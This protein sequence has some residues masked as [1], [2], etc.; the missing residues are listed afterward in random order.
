M[1][2]TCIATSSGSGALNVSS[3]LKIGIHYAT[4]QSKFASVGGA[5]NSNKRQYY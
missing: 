2:P 5:E 1:S 3:P 4:C